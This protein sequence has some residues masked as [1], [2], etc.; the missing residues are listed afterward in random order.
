[1]RIGMLVALAMVTAAFG[2]G[3]Y[4]IWQARKRRQAHSA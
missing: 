3:A 2:L 1:M 4:V